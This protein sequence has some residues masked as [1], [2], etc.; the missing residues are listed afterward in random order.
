[1]EEQP[2]KRNMS[3]TCKLCT[4]ENV[5]ML[6][7]ISR[8]IKSNIMYS[9][10]QSP[11]AGKKKEVEIVQEAP[12]MAPVKVQQEEV[13]PQVETMQVE[14]VTDVVSTEEP[15]SAPLDSRL[16]DKNWKVRKGA[17]ET[18]KRMF[19]SND[20][21]ASKYIDLFPKLA[22]D[23]NASALDSGL[24][25]IVAFVSNEKYTIPSNIVPALMKNV[26]DKGF[27]GRPGTVKTSEALVLLLVQVEQAE[28]VIE[29]L[30]AGLK[31]KKPK[32]PP[33]CVSTITNC[34]EAFGPRIISFAL[35]KPHLVAMCE[36]TTRNVRPNAM[37]LLM[38]IYRWVGPTLLA[39]V[40]SS[41]RPAQQTEYNNSI[42]DIT[43][44]QAVP[45][46]ALRGARLP[47]KAKKG[48]D[49]S[50]V[51]ATEST[52]DPREF[53]ETVNLLDKLAKSEFKK[54]LA[55]P[56]WSEKVAA[57]NIVLELI[58]PVPKLENGEYFEL[59][60]TLKRL[61]AESNINIVGKAINVLGALADG[62]RKGFA[63]H[64][65]QTYSTL[66]Q[67]LSDKK[68]V[69]LVA[70]N[71]A[72]DLYQQHCVP[73]DVMLEDVRNVCLG[74]KIKAPQA[75]VQAI[76]FIQRAIDTKNVDLNANPSLTEELTNLGATLI[77]DTDPKVRAAATSF[78]AS[79][80][81]NATELE[82]KTKPVL[83][84]IG[85]SNSRVHAK[86]TELVTGI[87]ASATTSKTTTTAVAASTSSKSSTAS[88][89]PPKKLAPR[90]SVR[91]PKAP[92]AVSSSNNQSN[93]EPEKSTLSI[94]AAE[95]KVVDLNIPDWS[96]MTTNFQ[97]V[98]WNERKGAF[99][100]LVEAVKNLSLD[101]AS[102]V[103]ALI[104]V[105]KK[106]TKEFKEGNVNVLMSAFTA[107]STIADTCSCVF[108]P[109]IASIVIPSALDK[110]GD[111]KLKKSI[112]DMLLTLSEVLGPAAVIACIA[113]YMG[114]VKSP[115]AQME[116][117]EFL[118][119]CISD[120]GVSNCDAPSIVEFC[121]SP[122]GIESANPK[123]RT[124]TISVISVAYTQLGPP[125]LSMVS[126]KNLKPVIQSSIESECTKAGYS[127]ETALNSVKRKSKVA[128]RDGN[129]G[130][131]GSTMDISSSVTKKMLQDMSNESDKA[132]WKTRSLALDAVLQICQSAGVSR[133][134]YNRAVSDLMKALK[135]R[136]SDSNS[137]LKVKAA[138]V[139]GNVASCVG[140]P[141]SKFSKLILPDLLSG[142]GDNKKVMQSSSI[143]ALTKW[144]THDGKLCESTI[145]SL[146]SYLAIAMVEN[147]VG[148][149]ELL[150]WAKPI[151]KTGINLAPLVNATVFCLQDRNSMV[152]DLAQEILEEVVNSVGEEAIATSCRDIKPAVMR[153]LTPILE[154]TFRKTR[155]AVAPP[156]PPPQQPQLVSAAQPPPVPAQKIEPKTPI[157]PV[158]VAVPEKEEPVVV[159]LL[160]SCTDCYKS[161][162]L[163]KSE[164]NLDE[165][166]LSRSWSKSM[167]SGF[168]AKLF[169]ND[170]KLEAIALLTTCIQEYPNEV[171]NQ[172]DF[173]LKWCT[174]HLVDH[175][176]VQVFGRVLE[177]LV[178]LTTFLYEKKS[179]ELH[180]KE[181]SI[182]FPYLIQQIGHEKVRFRLKID[183]IVQLITKLSPTANLIPH[184]LMACA[185][186]ANPKSRVEA[187]NLI[188]REIKKD[189]YSSLLTTKGLQQLGQLIEAGKVPDNE[190]MEAV[191]IEIYHQCN[192]NMEKVFELCHIKNE[193]IQDA[194]NERMGIKK[195]RN[196]E[197][198]PAKE[199][200][201]PPS[202]EN[203]IEVSD[204]PL[205]YDDSHIDIHKMSSTPAARRQLY[206]EENNSFQH[207]LQHLDLLLVSPTRIT[208]PSSDAYH[209]GKDAL[210]LI[211]G[212]GK[213]DA[214][215]PEC[216]IHYLRSNWATL[217]SRL[218]NILAG[219]FGSSPNET[220][221]I[222]MLSTVMSVLK[223]LFR[224]PQT[225]RDVDDKNLTKLIWTCV[226]GLFDERFTNGVFEEYLPVRIIYS[227]DKFLLCLIEDLET[228]RVLEVLLDI[229]STHC[230]DKDPSKEQAVVVKMIQKLM[231]RVPSDIDIGRLLL[232]LDHFLRQL[233]R[234]NGDFQT[235][236]NVGANILKAIV[237][238][239]TEK[240]STIRLQDHFSTLPSISPVFVP[241][242]EMGY[243]FHGKRS[244]LESLG[245]NTR[246]AVNALEAQAMTE[247]E[248]LAVDMEKKLNVEQRKRVSNDLSGQSVLALQERLAYFKKSNN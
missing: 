160:T 87:P 189:G 59:V 244:V 51:G 242:K 102:N 127:P 45:T 217:V 122:H 33:L 216:G 179:Y 241:L 152:R 174:L 66:L 117:L 14:H 46:M 40:I 118:K 176:N 183:E 2:C 55:L 157:E 67:K 204:S 108:P 17:F 110:I 78:F 181:V 121:C 178:Q 219:C 31:H 145:E 149:V 103:S 156:P 192:Q 106:Y 89:S 16:I 91:E 53:A 115:L 28:C 34:M 233:H 58:G 109:S 41:I 71:S 151:V 6:Q 234:T 81:K 237:E 226:T 32:V 148:R 187:M 105:I 225:P 35:L 25:A 68:S 50:G 22:Q 44:G 98:K 85:R 52:L 10:A 130:G 54:K 101:D 48:A 200:M 42:A 119:A 76:Q 229:L 165:Q 120:F 158:V 243:H 198:T 185:T 211:Y 154:K 125:F 19:E 193:V 107:I 186:C 172:L 3:C 207:V 194:L 210:K 153:A 177:F 11:V 191:F 166:E 208:P 79:I 37:K 238:S 116:V 240:S 12:Q 47:A 146:L 195:T 18:L 8:S 124:A 205:H 161:E 173:I 218:A 224:Q 135:A 114:K 247:P 171:V 30:I 214:V 128:T 96:E 126:A 13:A 167:D 111:R 163:A 180:E 83:D 245:P 221:D 75:R 39:D 227:F 196:D 21:E 190:A 64:A 143:E 228:T 203:L 104:L 61:L 212:L 147:K 70:T 199:P 139:I 62:L 123:V 138:Q 236:H 132:A 215:K 141:V 137:N 188:T 88:S 197:K 43:P 184:L 134:E 231:P 15:S 24:E 248:K 57:L 170:E 144:V 73:L 26:I 7:S 99:D 213:G 164:W 169:S 72:L 36:S 90:K 93:P 92:A 29:Q 235:A 230:L 49:S 140:P 27:S 159:S 206:P 222:Y 60:G 175:E 97:S 142:V 80:V 136:L 74:T 63:P 23:A 209:K 150:E 131:A 155:A 86:I 20:P 1:M 9:E 201:R 69:V 113:G 94:N 82:Q 223:M 38:E 239:G 5:E 100:Q 202:P 65:K 84:G 77:S 129:G 112:A 168:H 220:M 182:V 162:R 133:F 246:E 95:Q 4:G 56:K 232:K